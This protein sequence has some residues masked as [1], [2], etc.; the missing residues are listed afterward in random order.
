MASPRT[1]Q[2][3]AVQ[4]SSVLMLV[5]LAAA[6]FV[7]AQIVPVEFHNFELQNKLAQ[8]ARISAYYNTDNDHIRQAVVEK[9]HR[10]DLPITV[11]QVFITRVGADVTIQVKYSTPVVLPFYRFNLHFTDNSASAL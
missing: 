11:E 5:V 4:L 8:E 6:L 10:L 7:G 2:R 9:A 3:G 1:R